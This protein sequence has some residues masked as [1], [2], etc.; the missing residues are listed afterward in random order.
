MPDD[1]VTPPASKGSPGTRR[2]SNHG[3]GS[4]LVVVS[5]RLPFAFKKGPTGAWQAE[6]GSGGLVTALMPVLRNRGGTWIG[7][8]GAVGSAREFAPALAKAGAEAGYTLAAVPL[9]EAEI[10]DFYHGFANEV[11]WPLFHDLP[12]LCNFEPQYWQSY[13]DVNR[14]YAGAIASHADSFPSRTTN[15]TATPASSVSERCDAVTPIAARWRCISALGTMPGL[16][17]GSRL[18]VIDCHVN[19]AWMPVPI[20][21]ENASFAAQRLA[22]WLALASVLS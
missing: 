5:N 9:D 19:G 13:R 21:L 16:P 6:P 15:A 8:P 11:V 22:R 14:K 4:R 3:A 17:R 12:S 10:H 18:T 7:W 1:R 2:G 20:A